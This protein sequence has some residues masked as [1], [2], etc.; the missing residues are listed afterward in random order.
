MKKF[1]FSIQFLR[2]GIGVLLLFDWIQRGFDYEI[3]YSDNG[4]FSNEFIQNSGYLGMGRWSL[5]FL[6]ESPIYSVVLFSIGII[7]SILIITGF[8]TRWATLI[9]YIL[10]LSIQNRNPFVLHAGDSLLILTLLLLFFARSR[11][12]FSAFLKDYTQSKSGNVSSLF[13]GMGFV[14]I[15]CSIHFISGLNKNTEEWLMEKSAVF[16]ALANEDYSRAWIRNLLDYSPWVKGLSVLTYFTEWLAP[17]FLLLGFWKNFFKNLGLV[18]LALLQLGLFFS[19]EISWFNLLLLIITV[20]VYFLPFKFLRKEFKSKALNSFLS[21]RMFFNL[22]KLTVLFFTFLIVANS[23]FSISSFP[24]KAS[25]VVYVMS[26]FFQLN[27]QWNMFSPKARKES[28]MIEFESEKTNLKEDQWLSRINSKNH[29]AVKLRENLHRLND[30]QLN[31]QIK[32]ICHREFRKDAVVKM[33]IK[34]PV[35][36]LSKSYSIQEITFQ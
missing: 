16:Y 34:K 5:F 13:S 14:F 29:R 19:F 24:F 21:L 12:T 36:P 31:Q 4:L 17:L 2:I 32:N 27:F 26:D 20:G 10:V 35:S 15:L 28:V 30:L 18:L 11:N 9:S 33:R 8:F 1:W 6:H 3:F 23:F 25:R 22:E 7:S